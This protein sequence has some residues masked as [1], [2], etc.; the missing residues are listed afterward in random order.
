MSLRTLL[1]L[2]SL[3]FLLA[4]PTGRDDDDAGD[5]D[6]SAT[7]DDD[8]VADDDDSVDDCYPDYVPSFD[9]DGCF[10]WDGASA[11]CGFASDGT[12]CEFVVACG[13]V[14]DTGQC[15]IDCEMITTVG[16]FE[17]DV[18]ECMMAATCAD[19]CDAMTACGYFL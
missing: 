10:D 2:L 8:D 14:S 12:M 9:K 7:E 16:C 4:C 11:L 1:F 17:L 6:D 15:G 3:C 18:V 19:D 5:D 13:I